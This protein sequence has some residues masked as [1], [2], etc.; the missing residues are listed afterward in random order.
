MSSLQEETKIYWQELSYDLPKTGKL[1][2]FFAKFMFPCVN[3][4][5]SI[6]SFVII[7]FG[8]NIIMI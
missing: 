7:H 6:E 2:F 1:F 3:Q 8:S 5:V 4:Y